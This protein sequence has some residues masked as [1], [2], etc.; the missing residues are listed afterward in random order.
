[1]NYRWATDL[2]RIR[3]F[4]KIPPKQKLEWLREMNDFSNKFTP[5]KFRKI[6]L[7]LRESR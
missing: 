5:A 6:R 2:E 7:K 1:M 3:H 4:M